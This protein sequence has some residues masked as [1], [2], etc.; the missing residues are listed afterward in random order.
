MAAGAGGAGEKSDPLTSAYVVLGPDR[1]RRTPVIPS[2]TSVIERGLNYLRTQIVP[3]IQALTEP[4][5]GQ[6]PGFLAVRAGARLASPMSAAPCS[7]TTSASAWRSIARAFLAQ[8]LHTIDPDDPRLKTLLSDFA[9]QAIL[10]ATGTHWEE[11][12]VDRWNWNTDTRTTAIVLSTL[13]HDRSREP[14]QRQCRALADEQP[15][16]TGTGRARRRPPGR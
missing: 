10:S 7:F 2:T 4:V 3:L 11:K 1:G 16:R 6:P 9:S 8:A 5:S 14:A 15:H 12:E 13:S